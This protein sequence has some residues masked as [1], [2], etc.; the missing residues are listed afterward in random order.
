VT[1][2]VVKV[3]GAA[4][5]SAR[6]RTPLEGKRPTGWAQ[7]EGERCPISCRGTRR[8]MLREGHVGLHAW[9]SL[10]ELRIFEWG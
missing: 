9:R 2:P 4:P 3:A 10:G 7:D 1:G 8:C 6:W 5:S